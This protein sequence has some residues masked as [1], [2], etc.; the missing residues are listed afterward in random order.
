M[1]SETRIK[2]ERHEDEQASKRRRLDDGVPAFPALET[3]CAQADVSLDVDIMILDY[4]AY[5]ATCA[6]IASRS[7][8]VQTPALLAPN[9]NMVDGFLAIFKA[10]HIAYEM[11]EELRFRLLLL[12]LVILYTQRLTRNPTTPD[13]TAVQVLRETN[14][15]RAEAWLHRDIRPDSRQ[16]PVSDSSPAEQAE[17]DAHRALVLHSLGIPA[18]DEAY[19]DAHY[20]TQDCVS[21]LDLLPLF[22]RVS[23]ARDEM[24]G[25]DLAMNNTFMTLAAEFML[26]A[27]LEQ[28][29]VCGAQASHA[30]REAFAWGYSADDASAQDEWAAINDMFCDPAFKEEVHEWRGIRDAYRGLVV[31]HHKDRAVTSSVAQLSTV[32]SEHPIAVFESKVLG[33]LIAMMQ[34]ISKPVLVQLETGQLDGMSKVETQ[35]FLEACGVGVE[36]A[37]F[38]NVV[39]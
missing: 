22:M 35:E 33:F 4:L 28:V 15:R 1:L 12:K 16:S 9:A 37:D 20:G 24:N 36:P 31:H 19:D 7:A 10:R 5:Q 25:P 13:R 3:Q 2:A 23:A 8:A 21:L 17:L 27:V 18:E 34:S 38:K 26:Q 39:S 29:L 14:R 32:A 11:D 6:A 30:A